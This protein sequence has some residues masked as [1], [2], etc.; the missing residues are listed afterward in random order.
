[1]LHKWI[2]RSKNHHKQKDEN[3]TS[4]PDIG[5]YAGKI[6]RHISIESKDP[7]G[8]SL[9]DSTRTPHSV[10]QKAGNTLHV[11]S[12]EMAIRKFLLFDKD[13]PLDTL[14]V[15]ETERLLRNQ[16]YVR[17]VRIEPKPLKGAKDSLD[18]VVK[19]LD[20]WSLLPRVKLS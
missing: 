13:Q 3:R 15:H 12:K 7:F 16:N 17:R 18:I 20:S 5:P 8:T 19:I 14:Q 2:F 10:L 1:L 9:T 6:I 11:K 4:R